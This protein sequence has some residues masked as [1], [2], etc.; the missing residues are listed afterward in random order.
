VKQLSIFCDEEVEEPVKLEWLKE[1]ALVLSTKSKLRVKRLRDKLPASEVNGEIDSINRSILTQNVNDSTSMVNSGSRDEPEAGLI[2]YRLTRTCPTTCPYKQTHETNGFYVHL[3]LSDPTKPEVY[4]MCMSSACKDKTRVLLAAEPAALDRWV[5]LEL[6]SSAGVPQKPEPAADGVANCAMDC[7]PDCESGVAAPIDDE[8]P[9]LAVDYHVPTISYPLDSDE[10]PSLPATD[11]TEEASK[12]IA[13]LSAELSRAKSRVYHS[14]IDRVIAVCNADCVSDLYFDV[15]LVEMVQG[16]MEVLDCI[17]KMP[18]DKADP[19]KQKRAA[20][21]LAMGSLKQ[22]MVEYMSTFFI[23][24]VSPT[25]TEV[26]QQQFCACDVGGK[27]VHVMYGFLSRLKS[28]FL[29][30]HGTIF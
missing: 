15:E 17:S 4:Y 20:Q 9:P 29:D 8:V 22:A 21:L 11:K 25:K 14:M 1:V 6:S 10:V 18:K 2:T 16:V 27:E 3:E 23:L 24:V 30:A 13:D 26:V 7:V 28:M 5:K 12:Q 19:K